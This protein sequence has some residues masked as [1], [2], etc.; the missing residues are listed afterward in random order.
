MLIVLPRGCFKRINSANI[1]VDK[2]IIGMPVNKISFVTGSW[3]T[4]LVIPNPATILNILEPIILPSAMSTL[5]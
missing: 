3:L 2:I 1:K 4:S 5:R